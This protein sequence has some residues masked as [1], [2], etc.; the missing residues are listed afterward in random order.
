MQ[1]M[2]GLCKYNEYTI[3]TQACAL[4][5]SYCICKLFCNVATIYVAAT[6]QVPITKCLQTAELNLTSATN[7]LNVVEFY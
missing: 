7:G 5:E 4:Q 1:H 3:D 2:Q 6:K